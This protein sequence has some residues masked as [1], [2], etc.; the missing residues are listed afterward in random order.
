MQGS[1]VESKVDFMRM[2][3]ASYIIAH[4]RNPQIEVL[5]AESKKGEKIQRGY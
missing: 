1:I 5:A 3:P 4:N 2:D